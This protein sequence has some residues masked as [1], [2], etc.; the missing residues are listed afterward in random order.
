[1]RAYRGRSYETCVT[2]TGFQRKHRIT[3]IRAMVGSILLLYGLHSIK[4]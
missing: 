2:D 1:M 3:P 4:T